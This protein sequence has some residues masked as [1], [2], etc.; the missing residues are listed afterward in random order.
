MT[1]RITWEW[2]LYDRLSDYDSRI[3]VTEGRG[4]TRKD[5]CL[6]A[7]KDACLMMDK[8]PGYKPILKIQC[9]VKGVVQVL[10]VM[11]HRATTVS[12]AEIS[13]M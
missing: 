7:A 4:Y 8:G 10:T 11:F 3:A 5:E 9:D 6:A 2:K 12:L 13:G 1:T